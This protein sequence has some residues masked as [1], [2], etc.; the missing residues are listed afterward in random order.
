MVSLSMT[1]DQDFKVTIIFDVEYL[2]N[3][4]R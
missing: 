4:T 2:R 3:D 1:S